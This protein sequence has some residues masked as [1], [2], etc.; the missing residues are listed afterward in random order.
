[1]SSMTAEQI[2][3][4]GDTGGEMWPDQ[5]NF[6][7][8]ILVA[9]DDADIRQLTAD[10][11]RHAGYQAEVAEDGAIAW[12]ALQ[13]S[14]YDLLI[15]DQNMPKMSGTELLQKIRAAHMTLPVILA[16]GLSPAREFAMDNWWQPVKVLIKPY[17]FQKLL[18][19][20]KN[21]LARMARAND[22]IPPP[23]LPPEP[24]LPPLPQVV[25]QVES[26]GLI[27]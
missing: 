21:V 12:L 9:E 24:P 11:L 8:R 10:A 19:L 26:A 25:R 18:G 17:S 27:A 23:P 3:H 5:L 22:G 15:T 7:R 20:V 16:T 4:F 2:H 6:R 13:F 1:M 14:R